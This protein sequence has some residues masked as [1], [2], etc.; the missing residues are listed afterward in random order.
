MAEEFSVL[1]GIDSSLAKKGAKEFD[2]ASKKVSNS[3]DKM[4]KNVKQSEKAMVGMG[5]A[6]FRL[7]RALGIIGVTGFAAAM[8]SATR[9]AVA[10][11]G[12]MAEVNTLIDQETFGSIDKLSTAVKDLSKEFG[13]A[14]VTQAKALY[15]VISA[16]A[17]DAAEAQETLRA[18][19]KLAV[20]GITDVATAADGLT[21]IMNAYG[22]GAEEA[23]NIS[24]AMFVAMKAGKTTIGELSAAVGQ[25]APLAA[26]TGTSIDEML[27]AT[28]ALTKGGLSTSTAMAGLR[29]AL[30]NVIK[31]TPQASKVAEG[32]GLEFSAAALETKGLAAFMADLQEKTG[33]NSAVLAQLFGSVE[34]VNAIMALTSEQGGAAMSE[35][36]DNMANKAGETDVA[37]QK[38][39]ESAEQQAKI[40]KESLAVEWINLGN[41]G[42]KFIGPLLT[43]VNENFDAIVSVVRTL[44]KVT[45]AY[46]VIA[47]GIP[48][49]MTASA[50]ASTA[51]AGAFG[52]QAAAAAASIPPL[53]GMALA[54]LRVQQAFIVVAVAMAAWQLGTWL[55]ENVAGVRIFAAMFIG[56]LDKIRLAFGLAFK[57]IP[58]VIEIAIAEAVQFIKNGVGEMLDFLASVFDNIPGAGD[59]AL[60]LLEASEELQSGTADVQ[61]L[62]DE[63]VT[64]NDEF[65]NS[66]TA[67]ESNIQSM[68]DYETELAGATS[69]SAGLK[70][71]LVEVADTL[72]D[73]EE[74]TEGAAGALPKLES[75]GKTAVKQ[76][77]VLKNVIDPVAA[78]T[79]KY[80]SELILLRAVAKT[81][82]GATLNLAKAEKTLKDA[83]DDTIESITGAKKKAQELAD[84]RKSGI[85]QLE[86]L[87]AGENKVKRAIVEHQHAIEDLKLSE[88]F[89]ALTHAEQIEWL[90]RLD[91]AHMTNVETL[92]LA[93]EAAD[94]MVECQGDAAKRLQTLWE[95]GLENIQDSFADAFKGLLTGAESSFDGILDAFKDMIANML[96]AWAAAGVMNMISGQSFGAGGN[97]LMNVFSSG[98]QSGVAGGGGGGG[99]IG[100][101]GGGGGLSGL[102]AEG[103]ALGDAWGAF[104]AGAV[105]FFEGAAAFV[106]IG[107]S[108]IN[109]LLLV[110]SN[111][112]LGGVGAS[113]TAIGAEAGGTAGAGA[114]AAGGAIG[115]ITGL[116]VDKIFGGRGDAL[117]NAIFSTVGGIIGSIWGPVGSLIGGAIGSLVDNLI[118]GAEKLE[119]AILTLN[120]QG[121]QLNAMTETI[122][123][124]QKSFFRGKK[125]TTTLNNV[126]E[127]FGAI[128]TLFQD[129]SLG[130][131]TAAESLGG[132]AAGFL[133]NFSFERELNVK[134]KKPEEIKKM[135]TAYVE[136]L[137]FATGQAFVA[138]LE[139]VDQ[140][141]TDTLELFA[142]AITTNYENIAPGFDEEAIRNAGGLGATI[143]EMVRQAKAQQDEEGNDLQSASSQRLEELVRAISALAGIGGALNLDLQEVVQT[144]FDEQ[145]ITATDSYARMKEGFAEL[146]ATYDGSIESLETLAA[147]TGVLVGAQA[148]LVGAFEEVRRAITDMFGDT[149]QTIR[150]ALLNEEEL[151]DLR[152]TQVD[153]LV[154]QLET[155]TDPA[156]IARISEEINALTLD[157]FNMLDEGQQQDMGADFLTFL[158]EVTALAN[159][160]IEAGI[161]S[162]EQDQAN[163]ELEV[164]AQLINVAAEIQAQAA[165]DFAAAVND[166]RQVI[167]GGGGGGTGG[168]EVHLK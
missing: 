73:V 24:D 158:D 93:C 127:E 167:G 99:G 137:L 34:A 64:L 27:A 103:S 44:T 142:G 21:S 17:K 83:Y 37:L 114:A 81:A 165:A 104:A 48:I 30:S 153:N 115:A 163:L 46:L 133:D 149:A 141:I 41:E 146:L 120:V 1:V 159:E 9:A 19:N 156:E 80:N 36:M 157:S 62:K 69:K 145:N 8:A 57:A 12:A 51:M 108:S 13:Q 110:Q 106:G 164:S 78:A 67:I 94:K 119:K 155:A 89:L 53:T 45:I 166:F 72:E 134:G 144:A 71:G 29:A 123:S 152:Q 47:K 15:Q 160:R 131:L 59:I 162:V 147:A 91:K 63:L 79:D 60:G 39:N 154:S 40:L 148:Q 126:S 143:G 132:S 118:G 32:L 56:Q 65:A 139:G 42:L 2:M 43:K 111:S 84:A 68:V 26:A 25:L 138:G 77:K 28:A 92:G 22:L 95:R 14:P 18:A 150:E 50:A 82:E 4:N 102:F 161:M 140:F 112:G 136:D 90:D 151:Y 33:G 130:L 117:R 6:A 7:K 35:I 76:W 96:A 88:E 105:T 54:I 5:N 75:L 10:F 85:R 55:H 61:G 31:V 66:I 52:L 101:I 98:I 38:V 86:L 122:I 49:V 23:T 109:G 116:V 113:S 11:E 20:G 128:E 121:D 168:G 124:K 3:A 129:F 107:E 74:A 16:G 135:V 58:L 97:S 87:R 100:G 70:A 125:Y